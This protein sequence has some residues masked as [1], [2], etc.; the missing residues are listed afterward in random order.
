MR[1]RRL[2]RRFGSAEA[3]I[4]ITPKLH[5]KH[6]KDNPGKE[7]IGIVE[8]TGEQ[9]SVVSQKAGTGREIIKVTLGS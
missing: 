9:V 8:D 2:L 1:R 7:F 5:S 4:F 6:Q 3:L